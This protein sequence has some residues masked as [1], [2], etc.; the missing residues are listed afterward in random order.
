MHGS[1]DEAASGFVQRSNSVPTFLRRTTISAISWPRTALDEAT[2]C[3][4]SPSPSMPTTPTPLATSVMR[5]GSKATSKKQAA[6][7]RKLIK[8]C[9]HAAAAYFNLGDTLID[10]CE[11]DEAVECFRR[12][13]QLDATF[14]PAHSGL[15]GALF[16]QGEY[17]AAIRAFDRAIEL[18]PDDPNAR[19]S[20]S[21][22][23]L[24]L[25]DFERGWA[26][27]EW[28]KQTAHKYGERDLRSRSGEESRSPVRRSFCTM[29][30]DS[31]IRF[32]H[33]VT[34][35]TSRPWGD[36][37]RRLPASARA[38]CRTVRGVDGIV[39]VGGDL[40][41]FDLHAPLMSVPSIFRTNLQSIPA[42]VPYVEAEPNRVEEFRR[43]VG[44]SE[45]IKVGIL[46]KGSSLH[47]RDRL[48]SFSE[49]FA[50]CGIAE[51]AALQL[52]E[53]GKERPSTRFGLFIR[54]D[55]SGR[56]NRRFQRHGR[57]HGRARPGHCL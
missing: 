18:K 46:W 54:H 36:V 44:H 11:F 45:Q 27:H 21:L 38:R 7:F 30:R 2:A 14:V 16:E 6:T 13:L 55:R 32:R 47:R 53:K 52:A 25:G 17:D 49:R 50:D 19:F 48:R 22:I 43:L 1:P 12:S 23:R 41:A 51:R 39:C 28:R 26:D 37:D 8:L 15:G 5:Y 40:P 10:L 56:R 33:F 31:A 34:C 42:E 4:A 20:R 35:H 9:P 57:R 24:L 3:F 29:N